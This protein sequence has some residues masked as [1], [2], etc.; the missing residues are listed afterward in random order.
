[1]IAPCACSTFT[2][3]RLTRRVCTPSPSNA[4]LITSTFVLPSLVFWP[5]R[6]ARVAPSV[7]IRKNLPPYF[8]ISSSTAAGVASV[9]GTGKGKTK[10]FSQSATFWAAARRS[11]AVAVRLSR[12][13]SVFASSYSL[14]VTRTST[15]RRS[16]SAAIQRSTGA[17]MGRR[18]RLLPSPGAA[19]Q[20]TY[21]CIGSCITP[22][23]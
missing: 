11:L 3:S 20:H 7:A 4:L 16:F 5:E 21:S 17:R 6:L 14:A 13:S 15:F 1:M 19:I 12:R 18:D 9:P 10:A 8:F 22:S 23:A 2:D